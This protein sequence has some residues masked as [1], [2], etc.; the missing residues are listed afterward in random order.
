VVSESEAAKKR[1]AI[2]ETLEVLKTLFKKLAEVQPPQEGHTND[3]RKIDD[4]A[5]NSEPWMYG[6]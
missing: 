6:T 3:L 5:C 4:R 2:E 1:K